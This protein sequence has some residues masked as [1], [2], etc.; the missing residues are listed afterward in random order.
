MK[1]GVLFAGR[2]RVEKPAGS[3]GMADVYKA[4]DARTGRWAALKLATGGPQN[5]KRLEAEAATL[6][7]LDH[8]GIVGFVDAGRESGQ[9]WLA[10]HWVEGE[11]LAARLER[12]PLGVPEALVVG[13]RLAGALGHAHE[14]GFVHRDVKPGNVVLPGGLAHEAVLIDFGI[15]R[16]AQSTALTQ[17]D[18]VI[19]TFG[20]MSPEQVRGERPLAPPTDV[21]ALGCLLYRC[22]AGRVPFDGDDARDVLARILLDDLVPLRH[23]AP[24]APVALED[25]VARMLAKDAAGRPRDGLDVERE[26]ALI[27]R[28][29][30]STGPQRITGAEQRLVTLVLSAIHGRLDA[31][32]LLVHDDVATTASHLDRTRESPGL[33]FGG[34]VDRFADGSRL[35]VFSGELSPA[36]QAERAVRCARQ[37]RERF[38][39]ARTVVVTGRAQTAGARPIGAA[40]RSA[41]RLLDALPPNAAAVTLDAETTATVESGL[42]RASPGRSPFVGRDPELDLLRATARRVFADKSPRPVLV[43]G[44][45]A[46]GKSRL[47]AELVAL[48]RAGQPELRVL[49]AKGDP[50]TSSAPLDALRQLLAAAFDGA[51]L[52][53]PFLRELLRLPQAEPLDPLVAAARSSPKLMA[54]GVRSAWAAWLAATCRA[55]PVVL[56]LDDLQWFDEPTV[57]AVDAALRAARGL[58]LLVVATGRAEVR[59]RFPQLWARHGLVEVGLTALSPAASA[60]LVR[61]AH[62][63]ALGDDE[64][65]RLVE[66]GG[67]SPFLLQELVRAARDGHTAAP[68]SALALLELRLS[69]LAPH[70]RRLL[71]AGSVFGE[72]FDL[73]GLEALLGAAER[74]TTQALL[75][76]LVDSDWLVEQGPGRYAFR[77]SLVR[78]ASYAMLVPEDLALAHRLALDWLEQ[79]GSR[80]AAL[81]AAHAERA[82]QLERAAQHWAAAAGQALLAGDLRAVAACCAAGLSRA[83]QPR[84]RAELESFDAEARLYGGDVLGAFALARESVEHLDRSA[85]RWLASMG[86][87]A[88]CAHRLWH[89]ETARSV[90]RALLAEGVFERPPTAPAAMAASELLPPLAFAGERE[91]FD[92]ITRGLSAW[93]LIAADASTRGHVRRGLAVD[94]LGRG[95]LSAWRDGMQAAAASFDE[96]HDVSHACLAWA[97]VG[98]CQVELGDWA[99]A[100]D[101]LREVIR[102]A[103]DAGHAESVELAQLKLGWALAQTGA[104]DEASALEGECIEAYRAAGNQGLEGLARQY[105]G[106]VYR[107]RGELDAATIEGERALELAPGPALKAPALALLARVR[108]DRGDFDGALA[109]TQQGL[110]LRGPG[111]LELWLAHALALKASGRGADAAATLG[112]ARERLEAKAALIGQEA[113]RE[114]WR[115]QVPENA[116]I[117]ALT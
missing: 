29:A 79:Q 45:P 105:R 64:V 60:A 95:D 4:R 116:Q 37:L 91:L 16:G 18:M 83:T 2:F 6:R 110:D 13:R 24:L 98:F 34:A 42:V 74:T 87:L 11:S 108:L 33:Y 54:E 100:I 92:R 50:M 70:A 86:V 44:E 21:F 89:A 75:A 80:D 111:E 23:L 71:R 104:L 14:R 5:E 36:T 99:E 94:A 43:S 58:P 107:R 8:P 57:T 73:A 62:P 55:G 30:S 53:E 19:G 114:R 35:V 69:T 15:A 52:T 90:A 63:G 12:A 1:S 106:E 93:S 9:P 76:E 82:G 40:I 72:S 103:G 22:L 17:A 26:L 84:A 85:P 27:P 97:F 49:E 25:L 7:A 68:G 67:G 20:Y 101:S 115:T 102:L 81:L 38:P 117:L 59:D 88:M 10:M 39:R 66:R 61:A 112:R 109:L 41:I 96:G 32:T 46:I 3:G 48:L 28:D 56:L 47:A 113:D 51:G 65:E 77:H 78:E 31:R